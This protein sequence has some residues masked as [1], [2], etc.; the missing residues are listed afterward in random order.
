[1]ENLYILGSANRYARPDLL[2]THLYSLLTLKV[3]HTSVNGL[4]PRVLQVRD[5]FV[6]ARLCV[7]GFQKANGSSDGKKSFVKT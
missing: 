7:S 3:D 5:M 2:N 4:E 1:M 6:W